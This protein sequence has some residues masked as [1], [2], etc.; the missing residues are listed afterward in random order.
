MSAKPSVLD[1]THNTK[2][3]AQ[4]SQD[5]RNIKFNKNNNGSNKKMYHDTRSDIMNDYDE[6]TGD[7]MRLMDPPPSREINRDNVKSGAT[8]NNSNNAGPRNEIYELR[9]RFKE[10]VINV[11]LMTVII[12]KIHWKIHISQ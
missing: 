7:V 8:T 2:E 10:D 3:A 5:A 12:G 4:T 11:I 1:T 9:K 6:L